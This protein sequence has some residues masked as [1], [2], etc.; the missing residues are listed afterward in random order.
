MSKRRK[1]SIVTELETDIRA[2]LN[3]H[4]AENESDTPDYI[5]AMFLMECLEA[6]NRSTRERTGPCANG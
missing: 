3:K 4:S 1:M 6:F 2:A 5:L